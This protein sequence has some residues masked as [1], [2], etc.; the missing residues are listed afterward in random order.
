MILKVKIIKCP[1]NGRWY[2]NYINSIIE[3]DDSCKTYT[4]THSKCNHYITENDNFVLSI[5]KD[6]CIIHNFREEK[7]KRILKCF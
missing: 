5:D 6:D 7:I 1:N 3:V 2:K 4:V